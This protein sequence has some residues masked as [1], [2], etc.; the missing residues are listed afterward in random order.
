MNT[1][2][3]QPG[4]TG[5]PVFLQPTGFIA[6]YDRRRQCL[7]LP[8]PIG[9]NVLLSFMQEQHC[10]QRLGKPQRR[11]RGIERITR[12]LTTAR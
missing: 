3:L 1:G 5:T 9:N 12:Y 2:R 11:M 8:I 4:W 7:R 10:N 6:A